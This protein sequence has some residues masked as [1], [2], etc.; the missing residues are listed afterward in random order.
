MKLLKAIGIGLLVTI[1]TLATAWAAITL[2]ILFNK[3]AGDWF[4]EA[5]TLI[6]VWGFITLAV[7][8]GM[9]ND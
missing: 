9:D 5:L 6:F 7:Y 3:I 8:T 4:L 1:V 2:L